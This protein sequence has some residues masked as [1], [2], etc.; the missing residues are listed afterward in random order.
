MDENSRRSY[1]CGGYDIF[2]RAL[3]TKRLDTL[4]G[5]YLHYPAFSI[6]NQIRLMHASINHSK[7]GGL[8]TYTLF[9]G[10]IYI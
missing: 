4:M 8:S 9:G 10:C 2:T 1:Q 7:P 3:C 5:T 6:S